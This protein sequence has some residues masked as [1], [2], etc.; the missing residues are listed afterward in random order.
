MSSPS[1]FDDAAFE[2]AAAAGDKTAVLASIA[3][4][5][6]D[7]AD[8]VVAQMN[9]NTDLNNDLSQVKADLGKL[10][11]EVVD[12]KAAAAATVQ[13]AKDDI[14]AAEAK[15]TKAIAVITEL[16]DAAEKK[17]QEVQA[18]L[19][20]TEQMAKTA[21]DDLA[22][23]KAARAQDQ[24][25]AAAALSTESADHNKAKTLN[26]Q[27]QKDLGDL[28]AD[29]AAEKAGR[30]Q[31]ATTA[32]S[33]LAKATSDL[34]SKL[35][36]VESDLTAA[37]ATLA[38]EQDGRKQDAEDAQR[39][40]A[41]LKSRLTASSDAS[42][43]ADAEKAAAES[44]KK[45]GEAEKARDAAAGDLAKANE[46]IEKMKALVA[47]Y[48]ASK[49]ADDKE[50]AE[51]KAKLAS[52]SSPPTPQVGAQP[53]ITDAPAPIVIA[54]VGSGAVAPTTSTVSASAVEEIEDPID[55]EKR[56]DIL[57]N[58]LK[59]GEISAQYAK[60]SAERFKDYV[61]KKGHTVR[62]K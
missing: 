18:L 1:T 35:T 5:P 21:Q 46:Q 37:C 57:K 59:F 29:L 50:L 12:T 30:V 31:D 56:Y 61:E 40:I 47:S 53:V 19:K 8:F 7:V 32:A 13:T 10:Q 54:N 48:A 9:S 16:K 41:D 26:A 15:A 51:L 42:K 6:D 58:R 34:Q 11:Q 38:T 20:Q 52:V 44:A 36:A 45:L 39:T 23:E 24:Q 17:V 14:A 25:D 55:E 60:Q 3:S 49:L 22:A 33:N 27:L 62:T 43:L 28:K 4:H 2:Q